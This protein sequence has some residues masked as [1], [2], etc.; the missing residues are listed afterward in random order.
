MGIN[1]GDHAGPFEASSKHDV[2]YVVLPGK[3]TDAARAEWKKLIASPARIFAIGEPSQVA[4][5]DRV[6]AFTGLATGWEHIDGIRQFGQLVRGWLV[7]GEMIAACT[8]AGKMPVIWMSVWLEG[9]LVRNAA[10]HKHDNLREPWKVPLFHDR[11][12]VPPLAERYVADTF[13]SEL[14]RIHGLLVRQDE[15][16]VQAGSWIAEAKKKDRRVS[17]VAVGHSYP[18][19]LES[20][21]NEWPVNWAKPVSHV[22]RAHPADLGAG[23]VAVHFGYSPV[24]AR[25]V[26]E[27]LDR[28][29]RF[30]YSSPY[31]RPGTLADHENLIWLD[32]PWRPGDATVDVPGYSVRILPMSSSAHTMA[33]FALMAQSRE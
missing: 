21:P 22:Y 3:W 19:I 26:K 1:R 18:E 9:A 12:Y 29:V 10:F 4:E 24:D 33:Y 6:E 30:V 15:K 11:V 8:R 2:A 25:D 16:L 5:R 13:L 28:G 27:L 14:S 7:A 20:E 32:L 17:M 31:G 23:D